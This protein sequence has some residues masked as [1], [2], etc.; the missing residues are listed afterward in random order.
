MTYNKTN[1][2][3]NKQTNKQKQRCLLCETESLMLN[4]ELVLTFNK[5]ENCDKHFVCLVLCKWYS[6]IEIIFSIKF[7]CRHQLEI[8]QNYDDTFT[9]WSIVFG[10]VLQTV[11]STDQMHLRLRSN[12]PIT[13]NVDADKSVKGLKQYTFLDFYKTTSLQIQVWSYL[14]KFCQVSRFLSL[15]HDGL[16]VFTCTNSHSMYSLSDKPCL[17]NL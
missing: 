11:L 3:N 15:I 17:L 14:I 6:I 1:K 9:K 10:N 4:I 5:C 13:A 7:T 16:G 12:V 8:Q 2:Q